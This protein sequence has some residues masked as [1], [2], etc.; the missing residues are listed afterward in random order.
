M[1]VGILA[2]ALAGALWAL[3]FVAPLVAAPYS[4]FD[5]T[6]GRFLVF[7]LTSLLALLPSR[8]AALRG[9]SWRQ[10]ALLGMLGFAGNA[11]YYLFMSFAVLRVGPAI[12]AL[13]IGCL[14][15]ILTIVGNRGSRRVPLMRIAPSL[16]SIIASLALVNGAA[17]SQP[18][19]AGD[20]SSLVIGVASA[21]GAV[22]L[23]TW[24][25][26]RNALALSEFSTLSSAQWSLLT[27]VGT[28]ISLGPLLCIGL[29]AGWSAVP[30]I[31]LSGPEAL[32]ILLWSVLLG[33]LSS[34]AATWAWSI[35]TRH[36]SVSLASQLIV[37]ETIFTLIY[38]MLLDWR[39]LDWKEGVG[40]CLLIAGVVMAIRCFSQ[41]KSFGVP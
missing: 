27:G 38:V 41:S 20:L 26:L 32:G 33:M 24:Y 37:F 17:L 5:L 31:G 9:L 29:A 16:I 23:W 36:L 28:L 1:V 34:W 21:F 4:P 35:A 7:G 39:F 22:A 40:A 2:S 19:M 3:T 11:G 25:G 12:V 15:V 30:A 6:I 10:W 18:E 14:P 8:F 13:I